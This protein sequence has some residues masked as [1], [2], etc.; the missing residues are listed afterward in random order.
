MPLGSLES[1]LVVL[2]E[3]GV[4]FCSSGTIVEVDEERLNVFARGARC[5]SLSSTHVISK[6]ELNEDTC[7]I[8]FVSFQDM[9]V[10]YTGRRDRK[11]V[12]GT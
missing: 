10:V 3:G 5:V 9:A 11:C 7:H 1:T 4:G 6:A 8:L 2:P 12:P